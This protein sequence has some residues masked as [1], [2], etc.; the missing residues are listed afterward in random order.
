MV[1]DIPSEIID[2]EAGSKVAEVEKGE[3]MYWKNSRDKYNRMTKHDDKREGA[4]GFMMSDRE[5]KIKNRFMEFRSPLELS[6]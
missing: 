3:K 1:R 5:H 4:L 6:F 2:E